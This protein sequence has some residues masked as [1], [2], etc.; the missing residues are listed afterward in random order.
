MSLSYESSLKSSSRCAAAANWKSLAHDSR[1]GLLTGTRRGPDEPTT[2]GDAGWGPHET[3]GERTRDGTVGTLH[4]G[5][6][7]A[8]TG[9]TVDAAV[10]AEAAD[11]RVNGVADSS[12]AAG[13]ACAGLASVTCS[14]ATGDG[15]CAVAHCCAA[16]DSVEEESEAESDSGRS[17]TGSR[18]HSTG[19]VA[20][21]S[22]GEPC[23]RSTV[24]GVVSIFVC[25]SACVGSTTITSPTSDDGPVTVVAPAGAISPTEC[26]IDLAQLHVPNRP[27]RGAL[28]THE[29][30]A[31]GV[32]RRVSVEAAASV[33][34][35][36]TVSWSASPRSSSSSSTAP[37]RPAR[38]PGSSRSRSGSWLVRSVRSLRSARPLVRPALSCEQ[39]AQ[40]TGTR[41]QQSVARCRQ[42][43]VI[44]A[45]V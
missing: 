30:A 14:R 45:T 1:V 25:A 17:A 18:T 16:V 41:E 8:A 35:A 33:E 27:T 24:D 5:A 36:P 21:P 44:A 22:T 9:A 32:T 2:P 4:A 42:L 15:S 23:T 20:T 12:A 39:P 19:V 34:L 28:W 6:A 43:A 37:P 7:A 3:D 29:E 26:G 11:E 38:P 40:L 13:A 10:G 31:V